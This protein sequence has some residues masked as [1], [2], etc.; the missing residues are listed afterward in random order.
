MKF[1]NLFL[2]LS[3]VMASAS[4]GVVAKASQDQDP[5]QVAVGDR[6]FAGTSILAQIK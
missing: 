1:V 4:S 6:V 2:G 5:P 3:V